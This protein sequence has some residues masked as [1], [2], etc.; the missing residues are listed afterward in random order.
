MPDLKILSRPFRRLLA[1]WLARLVER[2]LHLQEQL[3]YG[4]IRM[5]SSSVAE[6]IEDQ[7]H[8]PFG[9]P[10]DQFEDEYQDY[11]PSSTPRLAYSEERHSPRPSHRRDSWQTI[12]WR[13]AYALRQWLQKPWV[14]IV[15]TGIATLVSLFLL[16]G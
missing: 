6:T 3:R 7:L 2:L 5:I 16:V 13:A 14:E 12:V 1:D 8:R 15:V 4:L 9:T 10:P 11:E